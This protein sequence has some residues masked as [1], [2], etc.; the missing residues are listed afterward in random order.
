M[1]FRTEMDP[2]VRRRFIRAMQREQ[3]R[4]NWRSNCLAILMAIAAVLAFAFC[5]YMRWL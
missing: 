4:H 5:R 2:D 1:D 3:R